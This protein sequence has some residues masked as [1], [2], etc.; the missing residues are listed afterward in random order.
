MPPSLYLY[1]YTP[2]DAHTRGMAENVG[3]LQIREI[4]EACGHVV[5]PQS[6]SLGHGSGWQSRATCQ[7]DSSADL[8]QAIPGDRHESVR[9]LRVEGPAGWAQVDG[10]AL[11]SSALSSI[12]G[13]PRRRPVSHIRIGNHRL[14]SSL[15]TNETHAE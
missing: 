6:K 5:E 15:D 4:R 7:T 14:G 3:R 8:G 10:G 13:C 1:L 9:E 12:L 11:R 2:S